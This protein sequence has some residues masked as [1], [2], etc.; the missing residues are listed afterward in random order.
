MNWA[1]SYSS[2]LCSVD[3]EL[4]ESLVTYGANVLLMVSS[5]ICRVDTER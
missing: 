4:K 1:T 5:I 2:H 3:G